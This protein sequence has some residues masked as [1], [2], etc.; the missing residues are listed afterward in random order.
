MPVNTKGVTACGIPVAPEW[1]LV[2]VVTDDLIKGGVS[3]I[4]EPTYRVWET[5]LTIGSYRTLDDG[6]MSCEEGVF[7][8]GEIVV[9]SDPRFSPGDDG[10]FDWFEECLKDG[11]V[12][13][14]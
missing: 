6:D 4:D 5:G 9:A 10:S 1:S 11:S 7:A 8:G 3:Q 13:P 2:A 12:T 14:V